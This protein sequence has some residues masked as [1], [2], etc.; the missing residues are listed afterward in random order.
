MDNVTFNSQEFKPY[1]WRMFDAK[2]PGGWDGK[3]AVWGY[4]TVSV[5]L[6]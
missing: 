1:L 2:I 4:L 6:S 5:G 3:K